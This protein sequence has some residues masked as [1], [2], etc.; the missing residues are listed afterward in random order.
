MGNGR[1]TLAVIPARYGS[2]RFPGKVLAPLGGKPIV[3]WVWERACASKAG[4]VVVAT[5][6]ER[7]MAAVESFGGKAVMTSPKHPSGSDRIWEAAKGGDADIIINVQGDEPLMPPEVIDGL[8]DA[9]HSSPAPDIATV[10]V[11]CP[12]AEIK[13][14]PNI[15]KALVGADGFALYFS[16]AMIPYLREGGSE[17]PTYRHWG[18][19][20]YRRAALAK[21]VSLPESPLERCEKLEQLRA[22]ENGMRIKAVV[23]SYQSI[24]VDTPEDLRK[25]EET[26]AKLK[27]A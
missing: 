16:R 18:I 11:P 7:V 2:M 9:M 21:F 27:R 23:T 12:R 19:Y 22:L 10:V 13:D 6:D 15:V 4:A 3:Q 26:I 1:K 17:A 5:D 24:G 14:N 8:I 25:A 20:A